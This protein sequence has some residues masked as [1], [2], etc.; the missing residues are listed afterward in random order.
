MITA[1]GVKVLLLAALGGGLILGDLQLATAN[2]LR[3]NLQNV[4]FNDG[5]TATGFFTLDTAA[6]SQPAD[7]DVKVTGG[8]YAPYEYHPQ[9]SAAYRGPATFT[10]GNNIVS[11]YSQLDIRTFN[12]GT[13]ALTQ[14]GTY[15]LTS[16]NN[17]SVD[18]SL[19]FKYIGGGFPP[20]RW[21]LTGSITTGMPEAPKHG[22]LVRWALDG[23]KFGNGGTASGSFVYDASRHIV[24]DFNLHSDVTVLGETHLGEQAINQLFPCQP[25]IQSPS[26]DSGPL[27]WRVLVSPD[28]PTGTVEIIFDDRA[29]TS[30][31]TIDLT[32]VSGGT[33]T[34]EGGSVSLLESSSIACCG[35]FGGSSNLIA[36]SL[37]GTPVPEQSQALFFALGLTA[38]VVF[39]T[40]R[41][42]HDDGRAAPSKVDAD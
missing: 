33:L 13:P 32:L 39:S 35:Q 4:T 24:V 2:V 20:A 27:C 41:T 15:S 9:R 29:Q 12:L 3:W 37:I 1:R 31:G 26:P 8:K 7:F 36:G 14:P 6:G 11:F 25:S 10:P 19:E 28:P 16:L 17:S 30:G 21:M 38:L 34:N 40:R 23:V 22:T 42:R 18:S 5:G